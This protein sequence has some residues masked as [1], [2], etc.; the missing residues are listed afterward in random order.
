MVFG[1]SS[2]S[3]ILSDAEPEVPYNGYP[4]DLYGVF[5]TGE[6]VHDLDVI[7]GYGKRNGMRILV[8]FALISGL[9]KND[10]STHYICEPIRESEVPLVENALRHYRKRMGSDSDIAV[11]PGFSIDDKS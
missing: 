5:D 9:A 2:R 11:I 8:G 6:V 3:Y 1:S 7:A 4:L 10:D